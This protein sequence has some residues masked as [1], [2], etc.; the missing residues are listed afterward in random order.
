MDSKKFYKDMPA[1]ESFV[2]VTNSRNYQQTP[3][4]WMVVLTDVI[5]STKAIEAGNYRD[6]N[7][8]GASSLIAVLN[9]LDNTEV[10]YVFGGDGATI[11]I[12]NIHVQ[13]VKDALKASKK[14]A[15][16]EFKLD[17]RIGIV[18]ISVIKKL[19]SEVLVAK[20]KVG[21][22]MHMATFFGGGLT[23]AEKLFK[24]DETY[25]VEYLDDKA[26]GNFMGLQC[27]WDAFD[28]NHGQMLSII[29]SAQ[30][31]NPSDR[32]RTYRRAIEMIDGVMGDLHCPI[33]TTALQEQIRSKMIRAGSPEVQVIGHGKTLVQKLKYRMSV[34][35]QMLAFKYMQA[36]GLKGE[37]FDPERY[38][39]EVPQATDSRKFDDVLRLI[40]DCTP[41]QKAQIEQ[42][43]SSEHESRNIVYGVHA[44]NQ[45]LMTCLIF[46]WKNHVHLVDGCSGGY[47]MAAKGLKGQI[48][49]LESGKIPA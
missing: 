20:Y 39:K 22:T 40:L 10:P 48:K 34:I 13:T 35:F 28:S 16:E 43:L 44:S 45:A 14:L 18:P 47:A 2:D 42:W 9:A 29:I 24:A 49:S 37:E 32:E 26:Q 12:P 17:L 33:T 4:D 36:K 31:S 3:D 23:L 15:R 19:G 11:L 30:S 5:G 25:Q 38:T 1:F 6:V 41:D 8:L 46:N 7:V 21:P 27:R